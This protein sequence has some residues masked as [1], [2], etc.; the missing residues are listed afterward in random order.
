MSDRHHSLAFVLGTALVASALGALAGAAM[1]V[2]HA[3]ITKQEQC[4]VD[5][6]FGERDLQDAI[7]RR[8]SE[9]YR[10]RALSSPENDGTHLV[11]CR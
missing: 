2:A 7:N 6:V 4:V 3:Q 1:P 5:R 11:T 9:G 8:N 10:V